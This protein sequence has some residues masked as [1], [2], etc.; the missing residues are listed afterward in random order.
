MIK[1]SFYILTAVVAMLFA[2][3]EKYDHAIADIEDRLDKI[4]GTSLATIDQ[5]IANINASLE[6]LRGVDAALEK[7]IDD[8]E[9]EAAD[10]QSQLDDNAAADAATK[11]ALEDEIAAIK[12]LIAALQEKDAELEQRYFELEQYI[13]DEIQYS[14]EWVSSTFATLKQY[15]A[16]QTEIAGIKA[17]IEQYKSDVTAEY[18]AA[19]EKAIADSETSMKAWVNELLADGYYDIAAIDAKL[20]ALET[21]LTDADAELKKQIEDQQAALEQARKDLTAAYE[22]AIADAIET[23]NGVI[24]KAIADAVKTAQDNLQSQI[25]TINN[26]IDALENELNELKNNFANRIQSLTFVPQ[27]SDGKVKMD[28]TARITQA[29][30]RISPAEIAKLIEA[31]DVK[32]FARY[33]NDPATRASYEPEL[34]LAV[35]AASGDETGMLEVNIAESSENPLS[36]DFWQGKVEAII[37][38]QITDDNGNNVVSDAIPMIAHG[39]VANGNDINGFNNG[40]NES[41]EASE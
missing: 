21:K 6:D 34:P 4:E 41:G 35:T 36:T 29:H 40:E 14:E 28:Y 11:K 18:T 39:Y 24:N 8:L 25:D 37:Y 26:R 15:E 33:T 30:F 16:M 17:L 5:Q 9:A 22:K 27:Y 32:A 19:I 7:L 31:D 38:I 23:N 1:K 3:C 13:N 12:A 2:S 20:A 10:L